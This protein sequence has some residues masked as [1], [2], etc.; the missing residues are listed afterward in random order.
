MANTRC[1]K[2]EV[3]SYYLYRSGDGPDSEGVFLRTGDLGAYDADGNLVYHTRKDFQIKQMGQRIELGEIEAAA[4]AAGGTDRERAHS[5][6][7]PAGAAISAERD[8]N[9]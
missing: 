8:T 4:M 5:G 7:S 2:C 3:T 1:Y 6:V 9:E